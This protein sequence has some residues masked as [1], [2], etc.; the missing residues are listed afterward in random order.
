MDYDTWKALLSSANSADRSAAADVVPEGAEPAQVVRDLTKSLGDSD[1]FVRTCAADTL[2]SFECEEARQ[3]LRAQLAVETDELARAYVLSSLA[4]IGQI[5][6]LRPIIDA[7]TSDTPKMVRAHAVCGLLELAIDQGIAVAA[8]LCDGEDEHAR[9]T[10][11]SSLDII[12]EAMLHALGNIKSLAEKHQG[13]DETGVARSH[14][15]HILLLLSGSA[16][17]LSTKE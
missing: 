11:F 9:S 7:L 8:D 13:M 12:V 3:A 6:D 1:P 4:K 5:G 14:I 15:E 17:T 2:A 16:T 10:T